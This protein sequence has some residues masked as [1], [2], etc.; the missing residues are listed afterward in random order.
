[1]SLFSKEWNALK[2]KDF[3]RYR[4]FS[5]MPPI[6]FKA[7]DSGMTKTIGQVDLKVAPTGS[8]DNTYCYKYPIL[9]NGTVEDLLWWKKSFNKIKEKK[10]LRAASAQFSMAKVML[11]GDAK[12]RWETIEAETCDTAP[13]TAEGAEPA[14]PLSQTHNTFKV[15]MKSS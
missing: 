9:S 15:V 13:A 4:E 1:M 14:E 2:Q 11:D 7:D 6:R 5:A 3:E 10:P 8:A 12:V